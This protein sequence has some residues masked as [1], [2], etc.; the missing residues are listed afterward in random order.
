M[1][2]EIA[3]AKTCCR[4]MGYSFQLAARVLLYASSHRQD[5]TYHRLCYTSRF[6]NWTAMEPSQEFLRNS[7]LLRILLRE[8]CFIKN[9]NSGLLRK[10]IMMEF[11][12]SKNSVLRE[13]W[14]TKNSVFKKFWFNT[15][16]ILTE[17]WYTKMFLLCAFFL[18]TLKTLFFP[19]TGEE[20]AYTHYIYT[21]Y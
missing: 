21:V 16:I 4:H 9:R 15:N 14:Y 12:F 5:N 10:T 19:V 13:F 3:R 8:F 11:W 1:T 7:G 18:K 17:F 6:L 2:T 20:H